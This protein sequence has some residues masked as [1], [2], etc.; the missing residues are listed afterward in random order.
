MLQKFPC[1]KI[2]TLEKVVPIRKFQRY[3]NKKITCSLTSGVVTMTN[4]TEDFNL[5]MV[6]GREYFLR[7]DIRVKQFVR[8]IGQNMSCSRSQPFWIPLTD[9]LQ[10]T[11]D[12][13][14]AK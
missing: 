7:P 8:S 14:K 2:Y 9:L 1:A 4:I 13:F 11:F 3:M 6:Q 5:K 12:L 10:E